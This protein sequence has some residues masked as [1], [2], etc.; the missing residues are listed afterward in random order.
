[1]GWAGCGKVWEQLEQLEIFQIVDTG[2]TIVRSFLDSQMSKSVCDVTCHIPCP[3][4]KYRLV[5]H[6]SVLLIDLLAYRR[7]ALFGLVSSRFF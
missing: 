2:A 1:M 3:G 5:A 4:V 6:D 7:V